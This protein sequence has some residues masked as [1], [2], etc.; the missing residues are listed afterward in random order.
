MQATS[1][2]P[3]QCPGGWLSSWPTA[4]ALKLP[5]R[6]RIVFS[7]GLMP[8]WVNEAAVGEVPRSAAKLWTVESLVR[9]PEAPST[10]FKSVR[11]VYGW[12]HHPIH[13]SN[14]LR[15]ELAEGAYDLLRPRRS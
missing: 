15:S 6:C 7:D 12:V 9:Q 8:A 10:E 3:S 1:S 13:F 2:L 11:V 5:K 4:A 14:H